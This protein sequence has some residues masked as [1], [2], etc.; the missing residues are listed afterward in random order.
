MTPWSGK[1]VPEGGCSEAVM[2]AANER[3]REVKAS[4]SPPRLALD[5][6]IDDR[7]SSSSSSSISATI[8]LMTIVLLTIG[9]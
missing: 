4:A 1:G 5:S 3:R 8:S 2:G 6:T 7:S 9:S